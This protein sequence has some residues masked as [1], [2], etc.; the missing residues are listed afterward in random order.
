M[1]SRYYQYH[2]INREYGGGVSDEPNFPDTRS[3]IDIYFENFPLIEVL[4]YYKGFMT[5]LSLMLIRKIGSLFTR[6]KISDMEVL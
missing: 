5:N 3:K 2:T 4:F 6:K 1:H